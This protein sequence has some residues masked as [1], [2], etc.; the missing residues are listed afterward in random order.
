MKLS[1][2]TKD[3]HPTNSYLRDEALSEYPPSLDLKFCTWCP[4]WAV[5]EISIIAL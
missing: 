4:L 2:S 5:D 1:L 3:M